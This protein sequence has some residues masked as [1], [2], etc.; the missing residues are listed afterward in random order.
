[1]IAVVTVGVNISTIVAMAIGVGIPALAAFIT[2]EGISPKL[3]TLI[4]LFLSTLVGVVSSVVAELP[5]T[6]NGW[7]HLVLTVLMT[8]AIAATSEVQG[9]IPTGAIDRIHKSTDRYIGIGPSTP[10]AA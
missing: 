7:W 8:Y 2:K 5:T 6:A 3:K 1:M 9:W 4:L 10:K